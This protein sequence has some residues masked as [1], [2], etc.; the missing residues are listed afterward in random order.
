MFNGPVSAH[1]EVIGDRCLSC[2][3]SIVR[4]RTTCHGPLYT[5]ST[6][7]IRP[8]KVLSNLH[9]TA[10]LLGQTAGMP[11]PANAMGTSKARAKWAEASSYFKI[12]H[13]R[14]DSLPF[15]KLSEWS[16]RAKNLLED[17]PKYIKKSLQA[18]QI[19]KGYSLLA[20]WTQACQTFARCIDLHY[21]AT[22]ANLDAM[23][24][25]MPM[26][27]LDQLFDNQDAG[28]AG[29]PPNFCRPSARAVAR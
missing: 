12:V 13:L 22:T 4:S 16:R 10:S 28:L 7:C 14:K 9:Q 23:M 29:C 17:L 20:L 2:Q 8:S 5:L 19:I 6:S 11:D 3:N 24:M 27:V 25:H 18:R 26:F 1:C 15:S 21:T